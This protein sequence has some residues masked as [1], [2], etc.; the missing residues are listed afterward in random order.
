MIKSNIF[1]YTKISLS[2]HQGA[3]VVLS[4]KSWWGSDGDWWCPKVKL[5][6]VP[7]GWHN[8]GA[9]EFAAKWWWWWWW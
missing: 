1:Y 7:K 2:T 9:V 3:T 6:G 4:K 5:F 8:D